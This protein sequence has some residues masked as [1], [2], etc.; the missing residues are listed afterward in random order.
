MD[1]PIPATVF[2]HAAQRP[3][4]HDPGAARKALRDAG[5]GDGFTT[6]MM[7]FDATGPLARELAQSMISAWK[8]VG[9]TVRPQSIEKAEWL[10]RLFAVLLV[11]AAVAP[12]LWLEIVALAAVGAASVTF[13]SKGNSTLQL[14]AAPQMRGRVM[15]LWAVAFLGSTPIGGPVAGAVAQHVGARWGLGLG[16]AACVVASG[17]GLVALRRVRRTELVGPIEAIE[18]EDGPLL[19]ATR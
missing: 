17:L 11:G 2:G 10:Q 3:Y 16:A 4:A 13:I 14:T 5:L 15:S 8:D 9:V 6:T 19:E 12:N 7:W 18:E 1:A